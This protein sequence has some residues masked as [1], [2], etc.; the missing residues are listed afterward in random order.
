MSIKKIYF[1]DKVH[2][3]LL[4]RLASIGFTCVDITEERLENIPEK[5]IDAFGIV[6]RSKLSL[7]NTILNKCKQL[8]FIARS[9]S[10]LENIDVSY[11]NSHNIVCFNSPEGNRNAVAEHGLGM[12]LT[13]F[14]KIHISDLQIR[15]GIWQRESNRGEEITGKTIGIIGYGN[16]GSSFAKKLQGF[17]VKVMAYDK[18]KSGFGDHFVHECTL[19][20]IQEQADVVSLHVPLAMDTKHMINEEF[21]NKMQKS[22]YLMNLSRG[23]IVKTQDLVNAIKA[24]KIK[25][26]CLDVLEYEKKSFETFFE[27]NLPDDFNFLI[28]SEKVVLTPHVAGWSKQSYFELSNVLADKIINHYIIH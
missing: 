16:N 21:I 5:L 13:L 12:L 19:Q 3:I 17:D 10:G 25:G 22:F 11:C 2:P 28:Q 6:I 4:E 9:G 8:S 26:A 15:N 27:Q 14:N 18:Y 23:K 20:A 7:D 1:I 24:D